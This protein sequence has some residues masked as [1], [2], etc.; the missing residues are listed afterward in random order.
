MNSGVWFEC[1]YRI[2]PQITQCVLLRNYGIS[3]ITPEYVFP[4]HTQWTDKCC[5]K[6]SLI[7]K[8]VREEAM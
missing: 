2:Y 7:P 1:N 5:Q 3:K 4:L 6:T 8:A